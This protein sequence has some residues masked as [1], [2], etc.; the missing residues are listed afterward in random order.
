[1]DHAELRRAIIDT[2]IQMNARGLNQGTSGN[3]AVRVDGGFLVTPSG[4]AYERL[5]PRDIVWMDPE[6]SHR[7]RCRPSSEWR[8]H[9]AVLAARPEFD[10]VLHAHSMFCTTLAVH[11]RAIPAFHYMVAVAGGTDIRCAPYRTPTTEALAEVVPPAMEGRKACLLAHHGVVVAE[12]GLDRA[13]AL[14]VEVETLAE[15][16]WRAL[17]LGPP[18]ILDEAQ[19]AGILELMQGYGRPAER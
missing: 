11:G 4:M 16:Y 15:Q 7:G 2:C 6:G 3:L 19:M 10:V 13:L 1:M 8:L 5:K 12:T 14:L 18:P 17:Q 9:R